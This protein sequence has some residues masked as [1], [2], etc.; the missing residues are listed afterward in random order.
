MHEL[1]WAVN[2]LRSDI[3]DAT[4]FGEI[5]ALLHAGWNEFGLAELQAR[6]AEGL[7]IRAEQTAVREARGSER[8][9]R[10]L[11]IVFGVVATPPLAN[12]VLRPLWASFG[13]WSPSSASA[14]SLFFIGIA[15]IS[16]I[17]VIAGLSAWSR[18]R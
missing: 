9:G 12:E 16:V 4:H 13:W 18:Q 8:V 3:A 7:S 1:R 11:T 15:V 10:W 14:E 17:S 5:R 2:R 6:I